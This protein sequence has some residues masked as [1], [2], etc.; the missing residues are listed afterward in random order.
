MYR[1]SG[2]KGLKSS[3]RFGIM[4]TLDL[5]TRRRLTYGDWEDAMFLQLVIFCVRVCIIDWRIL[6]TMVWSECGRLDI[7]RAHTGNLTCRAQ[8]L[9]AMKYC[10]SD[11]M[12]GVPLLFQGFVLSL[13]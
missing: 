1:H 8:K 7:S 11:S 2:F 9:Y 3:V 12:S 4:W 10:T 5:W 6:Q 13:A